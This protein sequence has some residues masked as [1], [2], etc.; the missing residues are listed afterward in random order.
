MNE[1][2]SNDPMG[3]TDNFRNRETNTIHTTLYVSGVVKALHFQYSAQ[4]ICVDASRYGDPI[5]FGLRCPYGPF[6]PSNHAFVDLYK[7][8]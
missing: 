8:V 2:F 4:L 5:L 6:M 7:Y 3:A 1:D